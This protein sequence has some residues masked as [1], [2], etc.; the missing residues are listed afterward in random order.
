MLSILFDWSI[1]TLKKAICWT[2][3]FFI[4]FHFAINISQWRESTHTIRLEKLTSSTS[5]KLEMGVMIIPILANDK[6]G[7]RES[8]SVTKY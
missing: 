2:R 6:S 1:S 4:A 5:D 7:T 8:V 3:E